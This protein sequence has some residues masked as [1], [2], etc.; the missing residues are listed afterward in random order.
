MFYAKVRFFDAYRRGELKGGEYTYKAFEPVKEGDILVL[1]TSKEFA[2]AQC[3]GHPDTIPDWPES[4]TRTVVT[5]LDLNKW[6]EQDA[7]RFVS[8]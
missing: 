3:T 6:M 4:T 1:D 8:A 5:K 2:I 7:S